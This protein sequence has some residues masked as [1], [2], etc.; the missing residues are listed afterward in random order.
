MGLA[1]VSSG[2]ILFEGDD[3]TKL[4]PYKRSRKGLVYVAQTDNVFKTLTVEENFKLSSYDLSEDEYKERIEIV[5]T[6]FSQIKDI[7]KRKCI[8]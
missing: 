5:F 3:I 7:L 4:P 8:S 2:K 1:S 6:L